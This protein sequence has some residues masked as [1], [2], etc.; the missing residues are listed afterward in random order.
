M[1]FSV[2]RVR[3]EL[4]FRI[5]EVV[6]SERLTPR[7]ARITLKHPDFAEFPSVGYDDHVKLFFASP[8]VEI[9]MPERGPNGLGRRVRLA[10]QDPVQHCGIPD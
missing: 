1:S 10:S 9:V 3:H 2:E 4:K 5:A 8:G 6:S 7:M